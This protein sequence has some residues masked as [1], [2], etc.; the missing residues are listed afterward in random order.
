MSRLHTSGLPTPRGPFSA[1]VGRLLGA[2]AFGISVALL[3]VAALVTLCTMLHAA[4]WQLSRAHVGFILWAL[5]PYLL[6][7]VVLRAAGTKTI[8]AGIAS[9]VTS[10]SVLAFASLMYVD[11]IFIHVSSTSALIF[12]FGPLYLAALA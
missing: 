4:G 7:L 5:S 11:A 9:I 1:D 2:R 10:A 12:L 6:L 8:A 3:T